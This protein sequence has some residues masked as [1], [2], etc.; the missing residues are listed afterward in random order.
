MVITFLTKRQD[1]TSFEVVLNGEVNCFDYSFVTDMYQFIST[2]SC[3]KQRQILLRTSLTVALVS[4]YEQSRRQDSQSLE[5]LTVSYF[6]RT[7]NRRYF[8]IRSCPLRVVTLS[9][10]VAASLAWLIKNTILKS[11][12]M[13]HISVLWFH[14]PICLKSKSNYRRILLFSLLFYNPPNHT[15]S[16]NRQNKTTKLHHLKLQNHF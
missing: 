14:C 6:V 12:R 16:I 8:K 9:S 4:R 10:L 2:V 13:R 3:A 1:F 15:I 7:F 5:M 11:H